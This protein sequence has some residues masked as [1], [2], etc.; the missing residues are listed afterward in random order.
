MPG[1]KLNLAALTIRLRERLG[2]P[3]AV[4]ADVQALV[5]HV[6]LEAVAGRR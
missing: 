5:G 2:Q 4:A 1:S 3:A 6:D